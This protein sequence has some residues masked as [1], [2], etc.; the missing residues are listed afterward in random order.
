[1]PSGTI[2]R[3]IGGFYY[4]EAGDGIYECKA[5]G[6]FRKHG[7]TPLPGDRVS[8]SVTDVTERTGNIEEILPRDSVLIRPAVANVNQVVAVISV[9]S[10]KPDYILLDKLLVVSESKRLN[11]VICINKIDLDK[12]NERMSIA[13]AYQKANYRIV[14]TS[15]KTDVGFEG[16]GEALHGRISVFAGQSGVGKSTILN[17]IMNTQLM[18]TGEISKKIERGKH[19]TRHTEMIK[20]DGGGFVVD[21]PGF[22]SYELTGIERGELQYCYPEFSPYLGKCRFAGCS[23]ISEPGCC[24]KAA[25]YEGMIDE[26]RHQRY[27]RLYGLLKQMEDSKW[28]K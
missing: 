4:V 1:M 5:R 3:G 23:H 18:Q 27:T 2:V 26:G 8:F 12:S 28:K 25:L 16:L 22:S 9:M 7:L 11:A 13:E 17:R 15:S 19:T 21:T 20:L 14:M 10:P 24:V 6:V